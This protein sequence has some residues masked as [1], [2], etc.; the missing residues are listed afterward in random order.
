MPKKQKTFVAT[1][2]VKVTLRL[3][4]SAEDIEEAKSK[5][6]EIAESKEA[7]TSPQTY[8]RASRA[9]KLEAEE[10]PTESLKK[11]RLI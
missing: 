8:S 4:V 6:I 9:I 7:L 5:A 2:V 1:V 11:K 3:L 10:A